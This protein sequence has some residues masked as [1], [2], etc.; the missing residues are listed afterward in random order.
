[1][2]GCGHDIV[3]VSPGRVGEIDVG[4]CDFIKFP[5][6]ANSI[7]GIFVRMIFG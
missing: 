1:M 4:L 5:L 2:F 6:R 7:I 3:L